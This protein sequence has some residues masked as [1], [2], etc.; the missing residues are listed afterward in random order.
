MPAQ[1]QPETSIPAQQKQAFVDPAI[2]SMAKPPSQAPSSAPQVSQST[3]QSSLS[4]QLI[5]SAA[6]AALPAQTLPFVGAPV[7]RESRSTSVKYNQRVMPTEPEISYEVAAQETDEKGALQ[8][9]DRLRQKS[10]ASKKQVSRQPQQVH[11][12]QQQI[13]EQVDEG[14][15]KRASRG[16]RKKKA[17]ERNTPQKQR[18][19]ANYSSPEVTRQAKRANGTSLKAPG[20]RQTPLLQDPQQPDRSRQPSII[21]GEIGL[22]AAASVQ[23]KSRRRQ[24]KQEQNGWATGDATDIQDLPEFDFEGN[25]SKFDKR[26][27]FDQIRNEDTTADEDRLVSYNKIRPGTV[28]GKNIH[29]LEN[30]L[31]KPRLN[32]AKGSRDFTSSDSEDDFG[33]IDQDAND[34]HHMKRAPSHVSLRQYSKISKSSSNLEEN[35]GGHH[36]GSHLGRS[37]RSI[38]RA[39]N[40]YTNAVGS[41]K[42]SPRPG[43]GTPTLG[44]S[45]QKPHLLVAANGRLCPTLTPSGLSAIEEIADTEFGLSADMAME[46]AGRGIAEVVL[47]MVNPGGRRLARENVRLNARPIVIVLVG[48][49][50]SGARALAAARHLL[51]RGPKIIAC[52]LGL[53]RLEPS[54]I[55][56]PTLSSSAAAAAAAT[57]S[58]VDTFD[59]DLVRQLSLYRKASGRAISWAAASSTHSALRRLDAPA[60]LIVD[61]LLSSSSSSNGRGVFDALAAPDRA[62][63]VELVNW[64]NRMTAPVLAVDCPSGVSG[65]TGELEVELEMEAGSAGSNGPLSRSG[66]KKLSTYTYPSNN[67]KN[68]H[69]KTHTPTNNTFATTTT[70]ETRYLDLHARSI[71]CI[72]APRTGLLRAL[73]AASSSSGSIPASANTSTPSTP[74]SSSFS[75]PSAAFQPSYK[76]NTNTFVQKILPNPAVA[77]AAPPPTTRTA[78]LTINTT[79]TPTTGPGPGPGNLSRSGTGTGTGTG[80]GI[81]S[82]SIAVP[83]PPP[84]LALASTPTGANN[85]MLW[86]V[87]VGLNPAWRKHGIGGGKGVRFG[88]DW[89]VGL[90]FVGGGGGGAGNDGIAST[91][92]IASA[93]AGV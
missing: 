21:G 73:I 32:R 86:A 75:S 46:N 55:S 27:V 38:P 45:Q 19:I 24:T 8:L 37:T 9:E 78:G 17:T 48:N 87:D 15:Q 52:V 2:V 60:E 20:W 39:A 65:A 34:S 72:G 22:K 63:A 79:A 53:E 16:N 69:H 57:K 12:S 90:R 80:I 64:A 85:W 91:S 23:R 47:R 26:T 54:S 50:R 42:M 41:P 4:A 7:V 43:P 44:P 76:N 14:H 18:V 56:T 82:S 77:A 71:V 11:E 29:P 61:A 58:T 89:V 28:G 1:A 3:S 31:E 67:H 74:S 36:S 35:L 68:H 6:N 88:P 59:R 62:S 10:K 30:V 5:A 84:P 66:M 83:Q 92:A 13:S 25:L 49:H 93:N 51:P 81:P 70:H 40:S 33:V